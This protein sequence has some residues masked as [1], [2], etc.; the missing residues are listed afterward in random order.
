MH[1]LQIQ[2]VLIE[3]NF[4]IMLLL[5]SPC[6]CCFLFRQECFLVH[7]CAR[8]FVQFYAA[9]PQPCHGAEQ[10]GTPDNAQQHD[11]RLYIATPMIYH[12]YIATVAAPV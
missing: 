4:E 2:Y 7:I 12:S 10:G 8:H 3:K 1:I 9:E 11:Y 6:C 5:I